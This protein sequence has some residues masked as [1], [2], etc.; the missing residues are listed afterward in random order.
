M[1]KTYP[2]TAARLSPGDR[3]GRRVVLEAEVL[4]DLTRVRWSLPF[5]GDFRAVEEFVLSART[6]RVTI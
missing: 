2:E 1:T 6:Y 5:E 3:V 4:G